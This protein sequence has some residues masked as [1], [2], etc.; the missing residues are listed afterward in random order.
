M[1]KI[2]E[3]GDK[4]KDAADYFHG[5]KI[6]FLFQS[7]IALGVVADTGRA[8]GCATDAINACAV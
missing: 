6:T 4:D 7:G 2:K 5:F 8:F 1:F 3:Y